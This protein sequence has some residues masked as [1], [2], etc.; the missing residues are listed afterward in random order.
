MLGDSW[1]TAR[2]MKEK[3]D[4]QKEMYGGAWLVQLVKHLTIDLGVLSSSPT[5]GVEIT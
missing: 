3:V 2:Q 1:N 5:F 4:Y